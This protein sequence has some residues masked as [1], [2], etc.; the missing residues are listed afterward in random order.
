MWKSR[1]RDFLERVTRRALASAISRWH[2]GAS[3]SRSRRQ[4]AAHLLRSVLLRKCLL[5]LAHHAYTARVFRRMLESY[6]RRTLRDGLEAWGLFLVS[7]DAQNNAN[8]AVKNS[9]RCVTTRCRRR[10]PGKPRKVH[11]R[12]VYAVSRGQRCT[13]APRSHL[14][15]RVEELHR[16]VAKGLDGCDGG[17]RLLSHVVQRAA[18][19]RHVVR[20]GCS[21]GRILSPPPVSEGRRKTSC[22]DHRQ[23]SAASCVRLVGSGKVCR[24][25][26]TRRGSDKSPRKGTSKPISSL[27]MEDADSYRASVAQHALLG[28]GQTDELTGVAVSPAVAEGPRCVYLHVS[29]ACNSR[30]L[31]G[32]G[33]F[34]SFLWVFLFSSRHA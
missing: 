8:V 23:G 32:I 12:C 18:T 20:Q 10:H 14:L 2:L 11:C 26:P 5:T 33:A 21:G 4:G 9:T 27:G 1:R 6:R 19:P 3:A 17:H 25:S 34:R 29:L 24:P 7:Q 30:C 28:E 15:R 31:H 16:L 13:C 22:D